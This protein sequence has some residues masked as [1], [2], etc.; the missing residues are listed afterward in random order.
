MTGTL[1]ALH[2]AVIASPQDRTVRLVYADALDET[3]EP[4]HVARAEF[5]RAQIELETLPESAPGHA[6]LLGRSRELFEAHWLAWWAPVAEAAGLPAPH[7]PGKRVRDRVA[8]ATSRRPR[9]SANWP[10]S[11]TTAETAVHLAGYGLEFRFAGGFP[12]E[13]R[14]RNFDSPEGGPELVH[15]WGDAIPLV[16]LVLSPTLSVVEWE[17]VAGP[18]LARL[19]DLSLDT[20]LD[21]VAPIVAA[22]P[23]LANL[24]RLAANP[25]GSDRDAIRALVASP[26]WGKLRVLRLTGRLSADGVRD[27]ADACTLR[28][29]E[30]LEVGIGNP[31]LLGGPMG[32]LVGGLLQ[33]FMRAVSLP[34]GIAPR[35]EEFGP[36]FEALAAAEWVR[37]LRVLRFV[38]GH[39]RGVF[40]ELGERLYGGTEATAAR[41][42]PDAAVLALASALRPDKLERLV[43]P[44]A[45]LGPSVREE[46]TTR[47][48]GKVVFT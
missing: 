38:S 6:D 5:I 48:G 25:L 4:A 14:F 39:P 34:V 29:L 20:M 36:A 21:G 9:R 3:G 10:Y 1:D 16:R 30:E 31:G 40:G 15:R 24:T 35:W 33:A 46:L 23:H 22:A 47:F 28:H 13:V 11:H 2:R 27:L 17:S 26:A 8:R 7:V 18:H 19:A 43:L 37:G 32:E 45:V 44:A 41:V 12:E 42:I